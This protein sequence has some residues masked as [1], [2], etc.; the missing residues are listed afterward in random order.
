M[1]DR[2]GRASAAEAILRDSIAARPGAPALLLLGSITGNRGTPDAL[3]QAASLFARAAELAPGDAEPW[4]RLGIARAKQHRLADARAAWKR[5]L[6][7]DPT[8]R[9]A[10]QLLARVGGKGDDPSAAPPGPR[11]APPH[12]SSSATRP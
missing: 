11:A 3:A 8:R 10:A 7:I 4:V 1:L 12:G 2:V 9:D 5:A 6:A